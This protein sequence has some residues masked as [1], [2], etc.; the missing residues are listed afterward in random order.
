M[1]EVL[2]LPAVEAQNTLRYRELSA[3]QSGA[4]LVQLI[5]NAEKREP[6]IRVTTDDKELFLEYTVP[7]NKAG[8]FLANQAFEQPFG[9]APEYPH[10]D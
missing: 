3:R 1:G 2:A 8:K 4:W 7:R 9:Y 10:G 6:F 5:Y